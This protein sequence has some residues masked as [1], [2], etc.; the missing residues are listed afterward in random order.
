MVPGLRQMAALPGRVEGSPISWDLCV[1]SL[2]RPFV[3]SCNW[4]STL[5]LR[6]LWVSP[7]GRRESRR[8]TR[9][10]SDTREK[11]GG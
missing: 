10:H 3:C 1:S 8:A 6:L 7:C 9:E 5:T 4:V 11:V 2:S